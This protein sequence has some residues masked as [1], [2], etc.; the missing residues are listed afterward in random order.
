M[1][2]T[3]FLIAIGDP[4]IAMIISVLYALFSLGIRRN[5][6][7]TVLMSHLTDS[8]KRYCTHIIDIGGCRRY[9]TNSY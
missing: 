6:S 4:P 8:G 7:M 9:E 1:L 3:T 5:K 2:V